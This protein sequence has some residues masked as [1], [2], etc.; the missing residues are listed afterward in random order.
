MNVRLRGLE[1]LLVCQRVQVSASPVVERFVREWEQALEQAGPTPNPL[2]LLAAL[3]TARVP[4][5]ARLL[6]AYLEQPRP[7]RWVPDAAHLLDLIVGIPGRVPTRR[8]P[9]STH[10][11]TPVV[12]GRA[13]GQNGGVPQRP[14]QRV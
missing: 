1:R 8:P 7:G 3:S 4:P 5:N 11:S 13:A 9:R 6:V 2:D 14:A 12:R 10:A